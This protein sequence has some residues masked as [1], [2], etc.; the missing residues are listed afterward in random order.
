M[1]T[2]L[3]VDDA[4]TPLFQ[5]TQE[6]IRL[7]VN[8]PTTLP[9]ALRQDGLEA[10]VVVVPSSSDAAERY[11][12]E[13]AETRPDLLRVVI[14]SDEARPSAAVYRFAHRIFARAD[15]SIAI[16]DATDEGM[17]LRPILFEPRL[18]GL[19]GRLTTVPTAPSLYHRLLRECRSVNPSVR[20]IA[21]LVADDPG[22]AVKLLQM[23][24]SALYARG[25]R[26]V[27]PTQAVQRIGLDAVK[28]LVLG[29]HVFAHFA[30]HVRPRLDLDRL[31]RHGLVVNSFA[32]IV[33][34]THG[35]PREA[36]EV[37]ATGG[38]LHDVGRIVLAA[39]LPQDYDDVNRYVG[40]GSPLVDAEMKVFGVSHAAVGAFLLALWGLP[41]DV[42]QAVARSH[43]ATVP[44]D[45]RFDAVTAVRAADELATEVLGDVAEE[46]A[47][48]DAGSA[49]TGG[50]H[51]MSWDRWREA[52][53]TWS[54][55]SADDTG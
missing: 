37:A 18:M 3:V 27:D 41:A 21:S 16:A 29:A 22:L 4:A 39:N 31:W 12:E 43:D 30:D 1:P 36:V 48:E 50:P 55:R 49:F 13:V 53:L 15:A 23:A 24:N 47:P 40:D 6:E 28:S 17:R 7:V 44:L 33:S 10:V 11:L 52:C 32:A 9:A 46:E 42:V 14:L 51:R 20:T 38:L 54:R 19:V 5:D 26:V 8:D 35:A 25:S 34:R 45:D 2:V